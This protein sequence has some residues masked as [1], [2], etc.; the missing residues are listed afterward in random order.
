M[1]ELI[2]WGESKFSFASHV[3]ANVRVIAYSEAIDEIVFV[4]LSF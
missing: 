4:G 3:E 1:V 2:D